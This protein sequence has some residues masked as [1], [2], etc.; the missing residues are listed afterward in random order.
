VEELNWKSL[1]FY[2]AIIS[3]KVSGGWC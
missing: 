1:G 2:F 3:G